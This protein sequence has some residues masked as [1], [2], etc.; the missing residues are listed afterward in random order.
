LK[1]VGKVERI[2]EATAATTT[3]TAYYLLNTA[4]LPD[5]FN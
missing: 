1:S 2:R 3:A 4:L 5:R